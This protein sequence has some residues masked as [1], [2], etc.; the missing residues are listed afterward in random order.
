MAG[1]SSMDGRLPSKDAA[2]RFWMVIRSTLSTLGMCFLFV[3][4]HILSLYYLLYEYFGRLEMSMV[5]CLDMFTISHCL[6]SSLIG[7]KG[8]L[9][10]Y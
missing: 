9:F 7:N 10:K 5:S 2:P 6:S 8:N 1:M 4:C 3:F